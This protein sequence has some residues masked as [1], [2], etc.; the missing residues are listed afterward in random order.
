[1]RKPSPLRKLEN[2]K[3][4]QG[5][6]F[7]HRRVG[8]SVEKARQEEE[9]A[10]A[11]LARFGLKRLYVVHGNC[12]HNPVGDHTLVIGPHGIGKTTALN[13]L[14][15]EGFTPLEEGLVLLGESQIGTMHVITTGTT[16]M[17]MR[18][19][20]F[21]A[22]LRTLSL[23]RNEFTAGSERRSKVRKIVDAALRETARATAIITARSLKSEVHE[24]KLPQVA[25]IL[26]F[27]HPDFIVHGVGYVGGEINPLS[28]AELE[29]FSSR[30]GIPISTFDSSKMTK[31]Q[32]V[33]TIVAKARASKFGWLEE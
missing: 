13:R 3:Y 17:S 9:S 7:F 27:T 5:A 6:I 14:K 16:P 2:S 11:I 31:K 23:K 19:G 4:P 32:V 18:I 15:L 25:Q 8:R 33:Q 29:S 22:L 26:F 10:K 24:P 28:R 20:N 21:T 30:C 1:M 12:F